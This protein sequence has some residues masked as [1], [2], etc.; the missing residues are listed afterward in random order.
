MSFAVTG[1]GS[2]EE[3]CDF[4]LEKW[5]ETYHDGGGTQDPNFPSFDL[6]ARDYLS[7]AEVELNR[8]L[9]TQNH[10]ELINCVSHL[11]RAA[12]C[13]IDT[14][15][16]VFSLYRFFERKNLG[17]DRKLDFLNACS[18]FSSRTLKR[19][20]TMRNRMEHTYEVPKVQDIEAYFDIVTAF[21]AVL[22]SAISAD[23]CLE[24]GIGE[25]DSER[26]CKENFKIEYDF[27]KPAIVATW[28]PLSSS[29][30]LSQDTNNIHEFG[31]AFRL[32][33]LLSMENSL[34]SD[35]WVRERIEEV[36]SNIPL[37]PIR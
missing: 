27:E 9:S 15:L 7:F 37:E 28:G 22:E 34:A 16:H 20:N 23:Y 13:Q 32:L 25:E 33:R 30:Q 35:A 29:K 12:E 14:F 21:V 11:K 10:S 36:R 4:I 5:L 2:I 1:T 31:R 17:F 3:V 24:Y 8:Y 18:I 6:Y 26:R 19:F